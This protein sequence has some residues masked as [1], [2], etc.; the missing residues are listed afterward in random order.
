ME[1]GSASGAPE[2]KNPLLSPTLDTSLYRQIPSS[3]EVL[4]RS[5]RSKTDE[6]GRSRVSLDDEWLLTTND[7]LV[8][9]TRQNRERSLHDIRVE[10]PSDTA[11]Q[12]V[13][14]C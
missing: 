11:L 4:V 9:H 8:L 6:R 13:A 14:G 2:Q 10:L 5:S 7:G 3:S 12:F 1:E